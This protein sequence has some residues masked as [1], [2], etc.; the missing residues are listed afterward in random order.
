MYGMRHIEGKDR[1]GVSD[2]IHAIQ[3]QGLFLRSPPSLDVSY[4]IRKHRHIC[5]I[6]DRVSFS[7]SFAYYKVMKLHC[8]STYLCMYVCEYVCM[9]ISMH[10]SISIYL[11]TQVLT[12]A[13]NF[14]F[15]SRGSHAWHWSMVRQLGQRGVRR[16]CFLCDSCAH[17]GGTQLYRHDKW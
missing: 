3:F 5:A 7:P 13:Y 4:G 15:E 16:A 12:P 2:T 17:R 6:Q 11:S 14:L 9:H 1:K 8:L 10:L